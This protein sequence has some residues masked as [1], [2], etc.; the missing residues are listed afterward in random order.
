MLLRRLP[1]RLLSSF[2]VQESLQPGRPIY[3]D[4]QATTP[5]D[6]RVLDAMLPFFIS[7]YGNPHSRTHSYGWKTA[8][9]VET[10][11]KQVAGL[12]GAEEKEIVFTSGATESNNLALK[13]AARFYRAK[14]KTHIV[15]TQ[16]E[17]KCVLDTCRR[18]QEEGF[19]VTFLPV[20]PNG[21]VDL[22][23]LEAALQP[24]TSLVSVMAVHNEI[25]VIQ[26]I[27][28]IGEICRRKGV[29]FHTDAAQATGKIPIDVNACNIDLMSIS[30]HKIYGPKGIGALYVRRKPRV[31]LEAQMNGG[32]QERGFRSGTLAPPLVVGIGAACQIALQE[33]QNDRAHIAALSQKLYT[34][35]MREIPEVH[36]NGDRESRYEGNWNFSFEY[37]E[38]ES[39]L[40]GLKAVALSSGSACTSASLEPSY[41]LRA[42]GVD[43]GLSHTSL[44]IGI[45]RFTT[46]AE[47][48]FAL[49]LMKKHVTRL[50]EMSPLWEMTQEGVNLKKIEWSQPH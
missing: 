21:L 36:L 3:L 29:L 25:G 23:T 33:M 19:T 20:K 34:G 35:V 18:L 10:A 32:G 37:V 27:K 30:G 6:P 5:V 11:R 2:T 31:R 26:P 50:R 8:E 14:G 48:T 12:I 49:D 41:V 4:M 1:L 38:G 39:L 9:A 28:A 22:V 13:G 40:M 15:T 7:D 44:R 43:P 24:N 45:G 46:E 47:I 16:T 42:L 17:H